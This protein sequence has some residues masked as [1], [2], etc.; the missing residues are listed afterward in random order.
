V[1]KRTHKSILSEEPSYGEIV[2]KQFKKN[3]IGYFAMWAFIGLFL[4]AVAAPVICSNQPFYIDLGDGEGMRFPWFEALLF[5]AN[6]Y[7]QGVDLFF[8]LLLVLL[9]V[10][11]VNPLFAYLTYRALF[12]KNAPARVLRKRR[13]RFVVG[14][15][16]LVFVLFGFLLA[17]QPQSTVPNWKQLAEAE[18][19]ETVAF[20]PIQYSYS[21]T[22][23]DI[24]RPSSLEHLLGTDSSGRDLF[25]RMLYGTRISLTIG[26]IAVAIYLT[27]GIFLG[28]IAG[29]RGGK[30]DIVI[31]R[32]I[33][34]V[35]CFPSFILILTFVSFLPSKSIFWIMLIIGLTHWTT[36]ARLVRGEFLRLRKG[37]FVQAAVASG[38]R[39]RNIIFKHIMP[40]AMGPVL[41]AATFGVANAILIEASLSFL[42]ISDLDAPSWGRILHVGREQQDFF[43]MLLPGIAIFITVSV[44]NLM[45]EALRDALDPKLRQ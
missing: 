3:R 4:L 41:V 34:V 11:L 9:L 31:S 6:V 1:V 32:L 20:P 45:G 38:Q 18:S 7:G 28:A 22:S 39:T 35:L 21:D 43:T 33:E 23:Y 40:N 26:V 25:T 30:W 2:W 10:L 19:V 27:I 42:G 37:D 29:Y 12:L 17:F 16:S 36:V 8:N 24:N 44:L 13:R 14:V 15:V 5:N